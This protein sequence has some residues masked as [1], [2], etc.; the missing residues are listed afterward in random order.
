MLY[1]TALIEVQFGFEK[2][3]INFG[4][5]NKGDKETRTTVLL[6]KSSSKVNLLKFS[7]VK[8]YITARAVEPYNSDQGKINVEIT[9][10][11]DAPPGRLNEKLTAV[12]SDSSYP[13]ANLR[14]IGTIVGNIELTPET[15]SLYIDTSLAA[16]D[17]A[18]QKVRITGTKKKAKLQLL[19]V[20]DPKSLMEIN[21]DTLESNKQYEIII[22]P[23]ENALLKKRNTVGEIKILTNDKEQPEMT[24]RYNIIFPRR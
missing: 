11:A 8:P 10:S 16:K 20:K 15:V 5:I 19:S 17:Q 4:R 21:V 7:S 6:L 23:N 18:E 14:I 2:N 1:V 3:S 24:F 13:A 12:L 22:K 9:L